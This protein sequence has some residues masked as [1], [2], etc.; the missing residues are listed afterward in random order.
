MLLLVV[1]HCNVV[2]PRPDE[3]MITSLSLYGREME[4]FGGGN[5][6]TFD[7]DHKVVEWFV[8]VLS[9]EDPLM[10]VRRVASGEIFPYG[11]REM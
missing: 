10:W 6:P 7:F 2:E 8:P 11:Q 4:E 3:E 9:H 1:V 5:L